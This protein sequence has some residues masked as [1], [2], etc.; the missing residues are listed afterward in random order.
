MI[1]Q[2][3]GR[4]GRDGKPARC[5]LLYRYNDI[6]TAARTTDKPPQ[7]AKKQE[8]KIHEIF[9][10]LLPR[11]PKLPSQLDA[12]ALHCGIDISVHDI[13]RGTSMANACDN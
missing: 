5:I 7:M 13:N 11:F 1:I 3:S 12:K 9:G 4:A 6:F 10:E 8:I 2:A